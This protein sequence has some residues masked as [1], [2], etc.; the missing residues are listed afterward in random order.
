M[1]ST[2]KRALLA[3]TYSK[4]ARSSNPISACYEIQDRIPFGGHLN[5]SS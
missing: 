1:N 2:W 5:L 3:T 4:P